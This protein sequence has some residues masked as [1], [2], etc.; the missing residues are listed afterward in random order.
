VGGLIHVGAYDASEYLDTNRP[1][2]LV[3][4]QAAMFKRLTEA[5]GDREDVTLVNVACG[6]EPGTATM[7]IAVGHE[8]SSS[9][10]AP[11]K[12]L[13]LYPDAT[14][15]GREKVK[16]DTLDN[17][18]DGRSDFNELVVD[19]QGYELEVLRGAMKTL[20]TIDRITLEVNTEEVFEGCALIEDLDAFLGPEFTRT[21]TDLY[22]GCWGDAVYTRNEDAD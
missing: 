19:T 10:L 18:V 4:P 20:R 11:L 16:V 3:E 15:E 12:H 8:Y 21:H 7:R 2:L 1:L 13:E 9:L 14:F 5:F 22:G 6:A 17:V